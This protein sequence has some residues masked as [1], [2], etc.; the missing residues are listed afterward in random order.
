MMNGELRM[1]SC[2]SVTGSI[3][4]LVTPI[5]NAVSTAIDSQGHGRRSWYASSKRR[6]PRSFIVSTRPGRDRLLHRG[7][8]P[9]YRCIRLQLFG[10][11]AD[12]TGHRAEIHIFE[13]RLHHLEVGTG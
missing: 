3:P 6:M 12:V 4:T 8:W 1:K 11:P 13:I 5:A 9:S 10:A 2:C 7:L